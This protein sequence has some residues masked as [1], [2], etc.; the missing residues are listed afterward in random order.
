MKLVK[1][2]LKV[3]IAVIAVGILV[4]T[5]A[6]ILMMSSGSK[7]QSLRLADSAEHATSQIKSGSAK[8][9]GSSGVQPTSTPTSSSATDSVAA[10][11]H[12]SGTTSKSSTTPSQMNPVTI[13]ALTIVAVSAT[14]STTTLPTQYV[15][16]GQGGSSLCPVTEQENFCTW[17]YSNDTTQQDAISSETTETLPNGQQAPV[18]STSGSISCTIADAPAPK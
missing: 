10:V 11:S 6:I 8:T 2:N 1:P 16:C 15:A 5:T 9:T 3:S 4:G 12:T 17:T 14:Q 13:P 7:P 18:V